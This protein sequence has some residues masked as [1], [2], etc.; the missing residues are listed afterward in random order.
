MKREKLKITHY[1][2]LVATFAGMYK[3]WSMFSSDLFDELERDHFRVE[4]TETTST[5][6]TLFDERISSNRHLESSD[7][8][9]W[10]RPLTE[11]NC[12]SSRAHAKSSESDEGKLPEFIVVGVDKCGTSALAKFLMQHSKVSFLGET[13]FFNR[14]YGRGLEY[15]KLLGAGVPRE[16]TLF[17][18]SPTYYKSLTVPKYI[19]DM[20]PKTKIVLVTCNNVRRLLSRY[21]HIM[22]KSQKQALAMGDDTIEYGDNMAMAVGEIDK[23]FDSYVPNYKQNMN[24]LIDVLNERYQKRQAPFNGQVSWTTGANANL[25]RQLSSIVIDGLY[26]VYS[27]HWRQYFPKNQFLVIDGSALNEHPA[28]QVIRLERFLEL[29]MQITKNNFIKVPERGVMCLKGEGGQPCCANKDKGRSLSYEF[30]QSA[31]STLCNFFRPF[32]LHFSQTYNV[33]LSY[34]SYNC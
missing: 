7:Y 12:Y 2:A 15:Y 13:Y 25:I 3:M 14:D 9:V 33:E 20:D 4:T 11:H 5:M 34:A 22:K 27:L 6:S 32:D 18:K 30:T 28:E 1:V 10:T 31:N 16:N 24:K 19:R 23:L 21:L 29:E 8:D 26:S 17:E